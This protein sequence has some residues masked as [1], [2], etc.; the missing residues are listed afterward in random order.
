M[1]AAIHTSFGYGQMREIL[2]F[3]V[4]AVSSCMLE[5]IAPP[6]EGGVPH[7]MIC[8]VGINVVENKL[9]LNF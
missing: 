2:N 9:V 1:F 7:R 8:L 3:R 6:A 5:A 4:D